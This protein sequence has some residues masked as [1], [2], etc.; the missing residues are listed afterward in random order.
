MLTALSCYSGKGRTY[1][2]QCE[3]RET[4][5]HKLAHFTSCEG[6]IYYNCNFP[7]FLLAKIEVKVYFYGLMVLVCSIFLLQQT[8][9][10]QQLYSN[11]Y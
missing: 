8:E 5:N 3:H 9:N 2:G 4:V 6:Q 10:C 7:N 1:L 11:Y